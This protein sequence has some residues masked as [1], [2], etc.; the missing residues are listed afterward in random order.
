MAQVEL[1]PIISATDGMT[2]ADL[3]RLVEDAKLLF[4]YDRSRNR[5]AKPATEYLLT[6][7]QTVRDNK[8]RYAE[9]EAEARNK[10]PT[11]PPWYDVDSGGA[12]DEDVPF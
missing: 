12:R 6:A 4:A 8:D 11:R 5:A 3:K 1:G 7:A 10:R 2:G 9:A